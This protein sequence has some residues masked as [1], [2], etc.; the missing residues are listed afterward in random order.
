MW[1][2]FR[3]HGLSLVLILF[4]IVFLWGQSLTGHNHYND[5]QRD[6]GQ[7][8]VTYFEYLTGNH[9]LEATMENWESEF[10]Q[11]FFF[12]ILTV[13]LYQKGSAESKDPD[14]EE[15]VDRDPAMSRR[16]KNVPWPVRKG[17]LV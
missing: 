1:Q 2:F 7:P 8:S 10:L 4:F 9:F 5:E 14:K 11:M 13:F 3:N 16:K 15:E 6:H 17:G 12:I